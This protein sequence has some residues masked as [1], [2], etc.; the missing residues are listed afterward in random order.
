MSAWGNAWGTSNNAWID[1]WGNTP[2]VAASSIPAPTGGWESWGGV[3]AYSAKNQRKKE[4]EE[5]LKRL[6]AEIKGLNRWR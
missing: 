4:R 3:S 5:R 2:A 6:R 1:A